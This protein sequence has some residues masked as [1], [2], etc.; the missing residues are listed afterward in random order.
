MPSRQNRRWT[1]DETIA[2]LSLYCQTPFG[3]M[4]AKNPDV[5]QV[6]EAADRTPASIALKLV[7]FASLDPEHQRRG[8]KG[9]SNVS[10]LDREVWSDYY[11]KWEILS[12]FGPAIADTD[13]PTD[14]ETTIRVRRGQA[15]FRR[16]V[17]SAYEHRCCIT[18]IDCPSLIRASHIIPWSIRDSSRLD[19]RNGLSLNALHDAAFDRGLMTLDDQYRVVYAERFRADADEATFSRFFK[20][21]DHTGIALPTRFRP[22]QEHLEYHRCH[23]FLN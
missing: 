16:T 18:G 10:K 14:I 23:I 2:V 8:V 22:S 19:P 15:F 6:A 17:C 11:G 20:P 4:H 13:A 3:R 5:Q 9:M 21:Y 12:D 7:N 1:R